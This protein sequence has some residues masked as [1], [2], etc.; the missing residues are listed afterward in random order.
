LF[1]NLRERRDR[2]GTALSGGEQQML[3]LARALIANPRMILLDEPTEGLAPIVVQRILDVLKEIH[4]KGLG[5][6]LVEQNFRFVT[7]LTDKIAVMQ[8]GRFAYQGEHLMPDE[9]CAI[10]ERYLGVSRDILH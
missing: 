8:A 10:A 2:R 6:L 3:A 7:G 4:R 9:I 5:M 1:P